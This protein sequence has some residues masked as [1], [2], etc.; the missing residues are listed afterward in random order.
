[1]VA[2]SQRN[3]HPVVDGEGHLMGIV[4]L[5]DIRQVMFDRSQYMTL[6]VVDS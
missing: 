3:L 2:Q 5:Q 4:D 6:R 1:M